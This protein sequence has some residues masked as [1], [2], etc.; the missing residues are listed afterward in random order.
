VE[1]RARDI[2][3]SIQVAGSADQLETVLYTT[4]HADTAGGIVQQNNHSLWSLPARP[5]RPRWRSMVSS[6]S[7]TGVDLSKNEFLEF[8][9]FQGNPRTA[10][11]AHVQIVVDLGS[12]NEDAL[13]LAPDSVHVDSTFTGRRYDGVNLLN[14]EREPTGIYNAEVDDIGILSDRPD[15]IFSPSG[16]VL[17]PPLCQRVLSSTVP[18]YRWGD[19]GARC[20]NGNGLLDTEDLNND[21]FLN[22]TGPAEN[23]FRWVVDV[24]D[25]KYFVRDGVFAA[26]SIA[27]WKLYRIPLRRPEF[28]LGTPNIRLIQHLR[29]TVVADP[30]QGG[31]DI[32]ARFALGRMRFLVLPGSAGPNRPSQ[33]SRGRLGHRLES[34]CLYHL[35]REQRAGVRLAAG[36]SGSTS[37]KGGAVDEF[38]RQINERSLRIVASRFTQGQRAE[39]Y[40]RFPS[41][42]QNVLGY[43]ELRVW[44]RGSW[45]W[46]ARRGLRGLHPPGERQPE[47]L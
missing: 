41:G 3:P 12:V 25:P 9:V 27:G 11:S 7:G 39:A 22:A 13:A 15:T 4:L 30:D 18:V 26:D 20:T 37:S 47:F 23:V 33:A 1:L 38:G 43:R 34:R 8:W 10:D 40:F 36:V 31:S 28:E 14:T 16:P 2:D 46:L 21:N 19:L 24:T 32:V 42:P 45:R 17:N 5:N 29:L 6:L 44:A 35:H